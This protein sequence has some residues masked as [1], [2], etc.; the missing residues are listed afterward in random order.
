MC[1][2]LFDEGALAQ[3]RGRQ[4][5]RRM[6]GFHQMVRGPAGDGKIKAV[7]LTAGKNLWMATCNCARSAE[8]VRC[9]PD[10]RQFRCSAEVVSPVP[11]PDSCSAAKDALSLFT[12]AYCKARCLAA[13]YDPL[14]GA[15]RK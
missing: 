1:C 8:R 4:I 9:T 15:A 12:Q 6:L 3:R 10:N 13:T 5:L 11:D 14:P 7:S 2:A